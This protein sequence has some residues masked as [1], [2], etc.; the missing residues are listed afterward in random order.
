LEQAV[1]VEHRLRDVGHPARM[2]A[3]MLAEELK[4]LVLFDSLALHQDSLRPLDHGATR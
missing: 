2:T 3:G 4:G 1:A